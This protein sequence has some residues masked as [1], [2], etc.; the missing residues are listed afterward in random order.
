M[1]EVE[2]SIDEL[3]SATRRYGESEEPWKARHEEASACFLVE[4]KIGFGVYLFDRI[5]AAEKAMRDSGQYARDKG[6]ADRLDKVWELWLA[7]CEHAEAAIRHFEALSYHIEPAK[8]FRERC[9]RARHRVRTGAR[10]GSWRA[11]VQD[12]KGELFGKPAITE[13]E[14]RRKTG[15]F[16]E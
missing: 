4:W 7:P 3:A 2:E 10:P 5:A 14:L 9:V 11:A 13:S 15:P 6:L 8:D 12:P 16:P 1:G